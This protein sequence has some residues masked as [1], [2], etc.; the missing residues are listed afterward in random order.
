MKHRSRVGARFSGSL[1]R[2]AGALALV[3]CAGCASNSTDA[4]DA[5]SGGDGGTGGTGTSA[6]GGDGG[7]GNTGGTGTTAGTGNTGT[8][9]GA[10]APGVDCYARVTHV[11][12]PLEDP[13]DGY[14][15][16]AFE[17]VDDGAVGVLSGLQAGGY[18]VLELDTQ[19]EPRGEIEHLWQEFQSGE[20]LQIAVSGDVLAVAD[21]AH[22]GD[23]QR[24][25]CRLALAGLGGVESLLAPTRVSD[26]PG[27]E[28]I[29]GEVHWCDVTRAGEGFLVAWLQ[30]TDDV[31]GDSSLF[32]QHFDAEGSPLGDRLTLTSGD[33]SEGRVTLASDADGALIA[34]LMDESTHI[35]FVGPEDSRTVVVDRV[36]QSPPGVFAVE[37]GILLQAGAGWV[38]VDRE[39]QPLAGPIQNAPGLI[40]P[41]ED[42]YVLVNEEE[43]LVAR[44]LDAA[45]GN[46]SAPSGIS[47]D[48]QAHASSLLFTPDGSRVGL[49][50]SE[51]G[52]QRYATLECGSEPAPV[53]PQPCMEAEAVEPLDLGCE[54]AICHV[55]VRLDAHT[56]G[57]RGYAVVGG[58]ESPV[59]ASEALAAGKEV[60]ASEEE[61]IAEN[62]DVS[63][64]ETGMFTVY[65]EPSDSGGFALVS[66][67]SGLVVAA[68]GVMWGGTGHYW[69]PDAWQPGSDLVC[70]PD[71]AE[72]DD[73]TLVEATCGLNEADAALDV[74]LRSNLAAHLAERGSFTAYTYI[75]TPTQ[76]ACN[77]DPAEYLVVLTQHND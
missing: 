49:V 72:P 24:P 5:G 6:G 54:D 56:L 42:G 62:A 57:L 28:T 14:H 59:E 3:G 44:T 18:R 27:G 58:D 71:R 64:P 53:G 48:R 65:A 13:S 55:L 69:M 8:T 76:G 40:A 50:Y 9:G 4:S 25:T 43:F 34:Q 31:D 26:E 70:G 11:S 7:T 37:A 74:V 51:E 77:P 45:L 47:T 41:L 12:E 15:F 35:T 75:Y 33:K 22:E 1:L 30:V 38:L 17:M 52:H 29:I 20:A 23:N 10:G 16:A 66:A 61:W 36:L 67:E 19:G 2:V 68:G 46:N 32:A 21:L 73:S 63:G 39:G 60:F